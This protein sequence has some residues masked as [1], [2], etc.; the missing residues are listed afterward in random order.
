VETNGVSW[1]ALASTGEPE[2]DWLRANFEIHPLTMQDLVARNQRPKV[3][4]FGS[5]LFV[6]LYFPRLE[7]DRL[8]A[9]EVDLIVGPDFI[10][11][12]PRA[13]ISGLE[14]LFDRYVDD[15]SKR[16]EDFAQG[17]AF[18]VYRMIDAAVQSSFPILRR[19]GDELE[20]I[21]TELFDGNSSR[22]VRAISNV[23]MDVI[24]F[25]R[26]VRPQR[27]TYRQL[28]RALDERQ[29]T[30]LDPYFDGLTDASERMWDVLETDRETV[31]GLESTNE[32]ILTHRL[33]DTIRVLTA[34][35]VILLP[36]TL[37]ASIFGMNVAVPGEGSI[38]AFWAIVAGMTIGL[39]AMLWYFRHRD[40]L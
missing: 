36:L 15:A 31:A 30:R 14:A 28:L 10:V 13:G 40:W 29:P 32:N 8:R 4:D 1:H 27:A 39:A 33:N 34:F 22:N 26:V 19:M 3:D 11:S 35:S 5:Y 38:A 20:R 37:V 2:L 23:K 16:T 6:V 21:Q 9:V 25:R 17:A 18:V 24:T 7:G 12:A